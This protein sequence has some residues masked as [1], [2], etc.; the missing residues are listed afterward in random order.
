MAK[1]AEYRLQNGWVLREY[2]HNKKHVFVG[3]SLNGG[4]LGRFV[5][6]MFRCPATRE[7]RVFHLI[8]ASPSERARSLNVAMRR[9]AVDRTRYMS[10]LW[11][12]FRSPSWAPSKWVYRITTGDGIDEA[13]AFERATRGLYTDDSIDLEFQSLVQQSGIPS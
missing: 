3:D 10:G 8:G 7:A 4:G 1:I 2:E 5:A 13:E 6:Q 9:V 12:R 11:N